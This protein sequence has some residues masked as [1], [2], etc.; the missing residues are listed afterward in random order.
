[1]SASKDNTMKV[2]ETTEW[3]PVCTT[4]THNSIVC[5]C[6]FSP[7]DKLLVTASEDGVVNVWSTSSWGLVQ[8]I[9]VPCDH[10][11]P[12]CVFSRCGSALV[13]ASDKE[14]ASWDVKTWR[15]EGVID[16]TIM[17]DS[18]IWCLKFSKCGSVLAAGAD[19]GELHVWQR[20]G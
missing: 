12:C 5:G 20:S 15:K 13:I 17:E 11:I 3:K 6:V 18:S 1:M 19:D 10:G 4:S 8:R 7:D 2:W 14:L 9:E 16:T